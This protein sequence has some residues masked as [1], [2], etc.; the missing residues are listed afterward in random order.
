[1]LADAIAWEDAEPDS[2]LPFRT[3]PNIEQFAWRG[4]LRRIAEQ[5]EH[6][7]WFNKDKDQALAEA[8]VFQKAIDYLNDTF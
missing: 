4:V 8:Q 3:I 2:L 5:A 6:I 7:T 1:M